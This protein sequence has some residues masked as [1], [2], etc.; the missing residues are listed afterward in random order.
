M[1][2]ICHILIARPFYI[3]VQGLLYRFH[4]RSILF[5]TIPKHTG[6]PLQLSRNTSDFLQSGLGSNALE[7][8]CRSYH[9]WI[10]VHSRFFLTVMYLDGRKCLLY[11]FPDFFLF[12]SCRTMSDREHI[13]IQSVTT[14]SPR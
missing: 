9:W 13:I 1:E 12:T 14:I 4:V 8:T 11:S 2:G 5:P 7:K 10:D 3:L 6:Q